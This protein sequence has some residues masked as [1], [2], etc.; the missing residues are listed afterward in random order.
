MPVKRGGWRIRKHTPEKTGVL[1]APSHLHSI[2]DISG[3]KEPALTRSFGAVLRKDK[4]LLRKFLS[5]ALEKPFSISKNLF[6][7]TT[8]YFEK[9]STEGRT[10]IEIVNEKIHVIVESK[11]GTNEVKFKQANKYAKKLNKSSSKTKCFIFLTE[12]GNLK[13]DSQL[14][15]NY[16][17]IKFSNLSWETTLKLLTERKHITVDLVKEY[18]NYL[19][20]GMKMKIH[21]ID[22]WAVVVRGKEEENFNRHNFYK[23]NKKHL[24][25]FI[26]KREWDKNLKKVV[27]RELRPVLKIHDRDSEKGK[28]NGNNYVYD[29]GARLILKEPIIKKFSQQ[30]AISVDFKTI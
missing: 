18:G 2:F 1:D 7:R 11:I 16:P 4:T 19:L 27:V 20:G 6:E 28:K 29:L 21:D 14:T 25:I 13:V 3:Y 8:F 24:P 9:S 10:D 26:G 17:N 22:L 15:R 5:S 23:H 12:I 30:S